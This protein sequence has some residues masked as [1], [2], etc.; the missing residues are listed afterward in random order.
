[1]S[2]GFGYTDGTVE[3]C[4][5][6]LWLHPLR[7][8]EMPGERFLA[9]EAEGPK[10]FFALYARLQ[11]LLCAAARPRLASQEAPL[12]PTWL[13][14]CTCMH[15]WCT[16]CMHRLYTHACRHANTDAHTRFTDTR[17]RTGQNLH[18]Q[19]QST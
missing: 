9:F 3:S 11:R 15:T 5:S 7:V 13:R 16:Y 6:T 2:F 4:S 10:K 17:V 8:C 18:V 14:A 19:A 1:M 12:L